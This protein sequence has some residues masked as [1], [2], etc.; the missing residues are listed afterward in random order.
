MCARN[1]WHVAWRALSPEI[2]S[3][4]LMV[5]AIANSLSVYSAYHS[6]SPIIGLSVSWLICQ[7][8]PFTSQF[9]HSDGLSTTHIDSAN[10]GF[11]T[12]SGHDRTARSFACPLKVPA[13]PRF[14][15]SFTFFKFR[16]HSLVLR[17]SLI[18]RSESTVRWKR[19]AAVF[20]LWSNMGETQ[21]I[22]LETCFFTTSPASPCGPNCALGVF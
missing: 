8:Q 4:L 9:T 5:H 22:H 6:R 19:L 15:H 3:G 14:I 11:P 18:S 12:N 13:K 20:L 2:S 16:P 1:D 10:N 7:N 17:W 21:T